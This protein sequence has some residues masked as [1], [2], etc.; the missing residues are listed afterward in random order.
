[1][2]RKRNTKMR[3]PMKGEDFVTGLAET[4]QG[5]EPVLILAYDK[6]KGEFRAVGKM[7][8]E[9]ELA[10]IHYL[11]WNCALYRGMTVEEFI[12][13][14]MRKYNEESHFIKGASEKK[15]FGTE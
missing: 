2:S 7:S 6:E 4:M 12:F 3:R 15:P 5:A 1:M 13:R 8:E 9:M 10:A 14:M 11:A